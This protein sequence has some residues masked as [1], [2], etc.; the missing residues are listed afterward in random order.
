MEQK[1]GKDAFAAYRKKPATRA[2]KVAKLE[3]SDVPWRVSFF[4]DGVEVGGGQY[5]SAAR[6]DDAGVDFMFDGG[7]DGSA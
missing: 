1:T 4:I 3:G 7:I 5:Q 2:F 6:A